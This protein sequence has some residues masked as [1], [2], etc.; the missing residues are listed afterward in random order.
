MRG[1]ATALAAISLCA[2]AATAAWGIDAAPAA[3]PKIIALKVVGECKVDTN[4]TVSSV[5]VTL[6]GPTHTHYGTTLNYFFKPVAGGNPI[7]VPSPASN[8]NPV[9]LAV[10]PGN[11]KLVIAPVGTLTPNSVQSPEYPVT[12]MAPV[13]V[14]VGGRKMCAERKEAVPTRPKLR[15]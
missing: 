2:T 4:G 5:S 10:Q 8:A 11:Y 15:R 3:A 9:L 13:L 7:M 14:T 12:V 1:I 6:E